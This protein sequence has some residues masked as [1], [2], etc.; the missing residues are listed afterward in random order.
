L[1]REDAHVPTV[2]IEEIDESSHS[3]RYRPE[4]KRHNLTKSTRPK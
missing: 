2:V 4:P 1:F 3:I